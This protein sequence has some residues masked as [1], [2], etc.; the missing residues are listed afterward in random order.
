MNIEP[1]LHFLSV[2]GH[3][4]G[5]ENKK[6]SESVD[7][8]KKIL[9]SAQNDHN[10]ASLTISSACDLELVIRIESSVI[11]TYDADARLQVCRH[12]QLCEEALVSVIV[13]LHLIQLEHRGRQLL[14]V[15]REP[16]DRRTLALRL[17]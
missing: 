2:L 14:K 8:A 13:E 17:I 15:I 1:L 11:N 4:K 7:M 9:A 12:R 6:I 5:T 16:V 10:G 3:L